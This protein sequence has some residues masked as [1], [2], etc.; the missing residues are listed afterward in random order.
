M[1]TL[2]VLVASSG[3]STLARTLLSISPQLTAGDELL[4]DVNDDAP[5]GHAARN[6]MM[7]RARG[8]FLLF[9]DDDD[10]YTDGALALVRAH[11]AG[12]HDRVHIFQM[13]YGNG[14]PLWEAPGLRCG[15]VSTQVVCV[16]N[17]SDLL[18]EWGERY[19]GD[20]D[21]IQHTCSNAAELGLP[22]P[23]WHNDVICEVRP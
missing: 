11:V 23:C 22:E 3:R 4:V 16:P 20:W 21:F 13:R 15:N 8:D 5:W 14:R 17:S 1:P 18:G 19:E 12:M 10:V 6:R 2:S 7:L 9:M